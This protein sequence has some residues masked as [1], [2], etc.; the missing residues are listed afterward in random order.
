[1]QIDDERKSVRIYKVIPYTLKQ[2]NACELPKEVPSK[3]L[4]NMTIAS[5]YGDNEITLNGTINITDANNETNTELTVVFENEVLT[6]I[7]ITISL[8]NVMAMFILSRCRKLAFQIRILSLNLAV[9]DFLAGGCLCIPNDYFSIQFGCRYK[10]VLVGTMLITSMCTVTAFNVDRCCTFYFNMRYQSYISEKRLRIACLFFWITGILMSYCLFFEWAPT[11][12]PIGLTCRLL[13][14]P[15]RKPVNFVGQYIPASIVLSNIFLYAYMIVYLK[16]RMVK[17]KPRVWIEDGA[18]TKAIETKGYIDEQTK[19]VMKLSVITGSFV[20]MV[21]PYMIFLSVNAEQI[22]ERV[23]HFLKLI[24]GTVMF[25]NSAWNPVLYVWRFKEARY[26]LKRIICICSRA[27]RSKF[28][29]EN[30]AY[31]AT[32]G[33]STI[34]SHRSISTV[35]R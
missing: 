17:V 8:E 12:D 34:Q 20:V 24:T 26:H 2:S 18:G 11:S 27:K 22:G 6:S 32:Y 15:P 21:A 30:K 4:S 35:S 7:G 9:T 5:T 33:I 13:R 1:M 23:H 10:K 16:R 25:M 14:D 29:K 3:M 19:I 31:F 28:A